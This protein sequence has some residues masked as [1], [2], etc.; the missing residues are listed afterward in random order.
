[1]R[2]SLRTK[3]E[4]GVRSVSEYRCLSERQDASRWLL[5]ANYRRLADHKFGASGQTPGPLSVMK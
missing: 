3:A 5:Q 2:Q 1:M 4:K